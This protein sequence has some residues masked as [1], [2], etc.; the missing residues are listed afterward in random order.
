MMHGLG[1]RRSQLHTPPAAGLISSRMRA[2]SPLPTPDQSEFVSTILDQGQAGSCTGFGTTAGFEQTWRAQGHVAPLAS[3]RWIYAIGRLEEY[4]GVDPA[5]VPALRDSGAEPESVFRAVQ[6]LGLVDW[7]TWQYPTDEETLNNADAMA[8]LVALKPSPSITERAYDCRGMSWG[9][10]PVQAGALKAIADALQH[11]MGVTFGMFVDSNYEQ[12]D[13]DVITSIDTTD[14]N[15]GG[16]WQCAVA[17]QDDVLKIRNS[18]GPS[19][20]KDG[21]FYVH[22][23]VIEDPQ[24]VGEIFVIHSAPVFT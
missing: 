10:I 19:A 11:R 4:A 13:G 20:G 14:P 9:S 6:K 3:P 18:W 5:R 1:Y 2:I 8:R 16:H 21:Y 15:G 7:S 22:K 17:V 12:S 23:S 24:I